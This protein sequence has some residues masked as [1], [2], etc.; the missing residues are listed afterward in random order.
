[1]LVNKQV[2]CHSDLLSG[3][4]VLG[5]KVPVPRYLDTRLVARD[6]RYQSSGRQAGNPAQHTAQQERRAASSSG[7]WFRWP[8]G[9]VAGGSGESSLPCSTFP[10]SALQPTRAPSPAPFE[11]LALGKSTPAPHPVLPP[12]T[13]SWSP[14]PM[15]SHCWAQGPWVPTLGGWGGKRLPGVQGQSCDSQAPVGKDP[16]LEVSV[17]PTWSPFN[18]VQAVWEMSSCPAPVGGSEGKGRAGHAL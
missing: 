8:A 15:A 3:L 6:S 13:A 4:L 14:D 7:S 17:S 2:S 1:M 9:T 18:T 16:A 11:P 10:V 5:T 12:C